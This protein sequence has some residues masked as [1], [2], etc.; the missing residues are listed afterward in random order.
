[1]G[2]RLFGENVHCRGIRH[3]RMAEL[4]SIMEANEESGEATSYSDF[5]HSSRYRIFYSAERNRLVRPIMVPK[6]TKSGAKSKAYV[7]TEAG[8]RWLAGHRA[9]VESLSAPK[10]SRRGTP[11]WRKYRPRRPGEGMTPIVQAEARQRRRHEESMARAR[12]RME[13]RRARG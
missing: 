5:P 4:L 6:R 11:G 7:L 3:E 10:E 13:D 2:W 8:R 1:M 12:A 9:F